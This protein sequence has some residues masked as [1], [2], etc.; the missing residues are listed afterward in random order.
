MV[1][2]SDGD[3]DGRGAKLQLQELRDAMGW[4]QRDVGERAGLSANHVTQIEGGYIKL[5]KHAT[6]LKA[7]RGYG[8]EM[9]DFDALLAGMLSVAQSVKL[10]ERSQ[11]RAP[12]A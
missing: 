8:L 9:A 1:N 11:R 12:A 10:I 5:D 6:R 4:T 2:A 7:A 3:E